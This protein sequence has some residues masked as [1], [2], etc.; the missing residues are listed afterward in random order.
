MKYINKI[1]IK[2]F[3]SIYDL[4]FNEISESMTIFTGSNDVGKSNILRALNLFFNTEVDLHTPLLFERDFSKIRKKEIVTRRKAR[5]LISISIEFNTP[6]NYTTLPPTFWVTRTFDRNNKLVDFSFD[7]AIKSLTSAKRLF[8]SFEYIYIPAVKD[9]DTFSQVLTILKSNLP[10]LDREGFNK[11][12]QKL[13][14]YGKELKDDL[15]KNIHLSP[16]L[17]L[18]MTTKELF[19]SLDFSIKDPFVS[20]SLSQRGDGIRCRFIPAIMNYI[21]ISNKGT[22]YIWGIEEPENSLEFTKALEL[23]NTFETEYSKHAQIFVTSHSP[24]FVGSIKQEDKKIIYLLRKQSEN[25][26]L[27]QEKITPDLLLPENKIKLGKE[28]GYIEL[29]NDLAQCLTQYIQRLGEKEKYLNSL[30]A[31][32]NSQTHVVF[33]E[34]STDKMYFEEAYKIF[35]FRDFSFE[36]IGSVIKGQDSFC[37]E[38]ALTKA[39]EVF[40][41]NLEILKNKKIVLLYD[42]DSKKNDET[43]KNQLF[44][45]STTYNPREETF[46]KGIENLLS[47]DIDFN[48][49]VFYDELTTVSDYG[50]LTVTRKLNK[51]KLAEHIL[52]LS[53]EEKKKILINLKAELEKIKMIFEE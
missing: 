43:I 28:L 12:N 21:S 7:K 3:R 29:Q 45:R 49:D 20:T 6:S 27:I 25:G 34:G 18:P 42:F 41:H 23:N 53:E 48:R 4:K 26:Y 44:V 14:Q 36:I 1:E 35:G 19:S 37:G 33:V 40:K 8:N 15:E 9:K 30:K 22:R 51:K 10:S 47:F 39:K 5:Q 16:S 11:F 46:K 13:Q 50:E 32:I 31:E 17:S 24:A 38:S 2:Y 52:S